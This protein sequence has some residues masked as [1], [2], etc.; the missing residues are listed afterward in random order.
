MIFYIILSTNVNSQ[1]HGSYSILVDLIN[2]N[3]DC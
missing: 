1:Y 2:Y 3:Y